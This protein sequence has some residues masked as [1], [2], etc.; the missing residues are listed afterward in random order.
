MMNNKQSI[1]WAAGGVICLR[2]PLLEC[3]YERQN[4]YLRRPKELR[5]LKSNSPCPMEYAIQCEIPL[6]LAAKIAVNCET[7]AGVIHLGYYRATIDGAANGLGEFV[8]E[9]LG[10]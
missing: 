6:A 3:L 2:C 8:R 10:D 4:A 9:L 1:D 5:A 7:P